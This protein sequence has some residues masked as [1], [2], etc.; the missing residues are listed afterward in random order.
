MHH[1][2]LHQQSKQKKAMFLRQTSLGIP[3]PIL[4]WMN[5][6][7]L[8]NTSSPASLSALHIA[9]MRLTMLSISWPLIVQSASFLLTLK[10]EINRRLVPPFWTQ[11]CNVRDATGECADYHHDIVSTL[12]EPDFSLLSSTYWPPLKSQCSKAGQNHFNGQRSTKFHVL[13]ITQDNADSWKNP[14]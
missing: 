14:Q 7:T 3:Y 12:T 10:H 2:N 8:P 13:E 5:W 4:L 11:L 9:W 6:V 1:G